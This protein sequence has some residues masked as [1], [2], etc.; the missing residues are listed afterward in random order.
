MIATDCFH[1]GDCNWSWH[2]CSSS[3]K[4]QHYYSYTLPHRRR[5]WTHN[6]CS[7]NQVSEAN[8]TINVHVIW[9]LLTEYVPRNDMPS[10]VRITWQENSYVVYLLVI[11]VRNSLGIRRHWKSSLLSFSLK[12]RVYQ[13]RRLRYTTVRQV[14]FP[15]A[16]MLGYISRNPRHA[17]LRGKVRA[18][19]SKAS[20]DASLFVSYSNRQKA[21]I[22]I[23]FTMKHTTKCLCFRLKNNYK[24]SMVIIN[25]LEWTRPIVGNYCGR[26]CETCSLPSAFCT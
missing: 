6:R 1:S 19:A 5:Q 16:G 18:L 23:P 21:S 22:R 3:N 25:F 13:A 20:G 9:N 2:R 4:I 8:T 11:C 10:G 7:R 24:F 17:E 26:D 12:I 14:R 15:S